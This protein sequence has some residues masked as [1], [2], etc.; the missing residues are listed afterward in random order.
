MTPPVLDYLYF[1]IIRGVLIEATVS[2]SWVECPDAYDAD[3]LI[4]MMLTIF[5]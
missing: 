1:L 3:M 4:M 2:Y 5:I